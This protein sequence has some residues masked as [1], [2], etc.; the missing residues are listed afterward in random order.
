MEFPSNKTRIREGDWPK[1]SAIQYDRYGLLQF[2]AMQ[3][4]RCACI[5]VYERAFFSSACGKKEVK[6]TVWVGMQVSHC[7][8]KSVYESYFAR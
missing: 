7:N 5:M 1:Y 4:T 8:S 2:A 6:S 3:H